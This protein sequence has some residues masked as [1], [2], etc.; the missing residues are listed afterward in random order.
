MIQQ[1]LS[2]PEFQ[3]AVIPFTV[4]LLVYLGLY[5][6]TARAALW[7][8]LAAF[9]VA[10]GLI[11]GLTITPL[12]GTRKIILLIIASLALAAILPALL[13]SPKL[14]RSAATI[15]YFVSLVWVFWAVV[16]RWSTDTVIYFLVGF[17]ALISLLQYLFDRL[18]S[19][20]VRL[21]AA[22]LGLLLGVG[23]CATAAASALLGQLGLALAAGCGGA[24][25]AWV[26]VGDA[27][28]SPGLAQPIATLP[29]V[30]APALLGF[31]AFIFARL[32]W[33]AL[34]PLAAIPLL[35]S[36]VPL[37]PESRFLQAALTSLPGIAVAAA[38]AF[39][40]W[41]SA[42]SSSGY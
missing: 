31:A 26:L 11:N 27:K 28:G 40:I 2:R 24:F 19:S 3:S 35:V 39:W 29:L 8:L 6:L 30:L 21:Q 34:I 1:I 25:L 37:K 10:A 18:A 36:L 5:K 33:Y 4:A 16:S 15:V 42:G 20:P 12:T 7:A 32:P 41:Q 38:V 14:Q 13:T 23:L 22:S 9:A 17:S